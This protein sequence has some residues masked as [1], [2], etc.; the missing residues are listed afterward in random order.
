MCKNGKIESRSGSNIENWGWYARV[1]P[2]KGCRLENYGYNGGRKHKDVCG[3]PI[4]SGYEFAFSGLMRTE[5]SANITIFAE[6]ISG[7]ILTD[8]CVITIDRDWKTVC[9]TLKAMTS[10]YGKL[11]IEINSNTPVDIDD[12]IFMNSDTWGKDNPKWSQGMMRRDMVQTLV[13]LKP[14]FV[15]FP[16]G[17]LVEGIDSGNHYQWKDSIGPLHDRKQEYNLW[18]ACAPKGDYIQ[19]RQIGFYEFFLLC[20]DLK[21][22]PLPVVWAGMNCQIRRRGKISVEGEEFQKEVIQNALDLIEYANGNP[23]ESKWADLRAKAGHPEPFNMKYIGI[24]NENFGEDYLRRFDMISREIR[25]HYPD[26]ICILSAGMNPDGAEHELAMQHAHSLGYDVM[27][28][29]H[30]YRTPEWTEEQHT[31]Y[32]NLKRDHVKI[33]LGEYAAAE[34]VGNKNPNSFGSALSEAA[35]LTGAE[36]NSDIVAMTCYAPL[37]SMVEG[38][39]WVQNLIDFNPFYVLE[40]CNYY[41]QKLFGTTVGDHTVRI[42]GDTPEQ[43]YISATASEDT[44]YVKIV[45]TSTEERALCLKLE[46]VI[47]N[48]AVQTVFQS[49][50]LSARNTM[51]FFGKPEYQVKPVEK[52][53]PILNQQ[54]V[55]Q[56]QKQSVNILHVKLM[57]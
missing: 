36:R 9:G 25:K 38:N 2:K 5:D 21:A 45:N 17:C 20:E 40:T 47:E 28:D 50:D 26:I 27:V 19:S 30:F 53:V 24:G 15:R 57:S 51:D 6:D 39:Q 32:D 16:G 12:V 4:K 44:L 43:V 8:K 52:T 3:M 31:R 49:D 22:E 11:V 56:L 7:K 18:A 14:G 41:V 1:N 35:F 34:P 23:K 55:L 33:F 42:D 13:D 37:F 29:E 10:G 48:D 46:G 54:A